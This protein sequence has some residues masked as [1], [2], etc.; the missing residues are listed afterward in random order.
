MNAFNW[1]NS[2]MWTA[3]SLLFLLLALMVGPAPVLAA[4][5][6]EGVGLVLYEVTEDMYL[7]DKDGKPTGNLANAVARAAVAQLSGVAKLGT[8]LCPWEVLVVAAGARGCVVNASGGDNLS[9]LPPDAGK[10]SI[11]GTFAVVVQDNNKADSPEFVVMTGS[12]GG[13]ADL[14]LPFAGKAP[15]G[16]IS[17]GQGV[18]DQTGQTFT[19]S[20]KFRLPYALDPQGTHAKPRRHQSAYYLSDDYRTPVAV[21]GGERSLGWPTVRLEIKF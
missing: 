5:V 21:E 19:F 3:L 10:G 15:I 1:H 2:A 18:V 12:F 20:G 7:L 8:P 14:S 11:G 4:G 17:N 9:L 13:S 6:G 16:F